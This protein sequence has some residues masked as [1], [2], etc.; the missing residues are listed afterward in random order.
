MPK[1]PGAPY[2]LTE[3][4]G[5]WGK[6]IPESKKFKSKL[7]D[8]L[9]N[10]VVEPAANAGYPNLGAAAATVP[11]TLAEF[12]IPENTAEFAPGM[13]GVGKLSRRSN[14]FVKEL[15]EAYNSGKLNQNT[16]TEI[17]KDLL[18]QIKSLYDFLK[19]TP[20]NNY[21]AI[22]SIK[23][24]I[25]KLEADYHRI[26]NLSS[27]LKSDWIKGERIKK[28]FYSKGAMDND[29]ID[30]KYELER[31][32]EQGLPKR[33]AVF[34][35]YDPWD[36]YTV[37]ETHNPSIKRWAEDIEKTRDLA[38]GSREGQ[39]YLRPKGYA[40]QKS[41]KIP[42][43]E[44]ESMPSRDEYDKMLRGQN[45]GQQYFDEMS[46][47]Y[48][49]YLQDQEEPDLFNDLIKKSWKGE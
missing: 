18:N 5:S 25:K 19:A 23:D 26:T 42:Q 17:S 44:F 47:G 7:E 3:M 13:A 2:A 33:S 35:R 11:A 6:E 39:T 16:L 36:L 24:K 14:K 30:L 49:R 9:T 48:K 10:N 32:K 38:L 43:P 27:T 37:G 28:G 20:E 22:K 41:T 45:P 21:Q 29:K 46:E 15:Q 40:K 12:F 8:W 1:Y 4:K 31:A 34:D